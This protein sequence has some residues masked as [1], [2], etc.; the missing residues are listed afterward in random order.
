MKHPSKMVGFR[1]Q[2]LKPAPQPFHDFGLETPSQEGW[3]HDPGL[4]TPGQGLV[5]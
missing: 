4:E 3:F 1:T 2:V 5:S